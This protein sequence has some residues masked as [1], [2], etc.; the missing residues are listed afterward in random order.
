MTSAIPPPPARYDIYAYVHK[1]L[2]FC[3]TESLGSVGRV[4]ALDD[5]DVARV[6]DG[7]RELLAL[8][9]RHLQHE[10]RHLHTALQA[11]RPGSAARTAGDHLQ[12]A[13]AIGVLHTQVDEVA[14]AAVGDRAA[15]LRGL[16]REL[17]LF[18][19]DNL[20]HMHVEETENNAVLWATHSDDEL[21]A[22]EAAIVASHAPQEIAVVLRWMVP[23]MAPAERATLLAG[24]AQSAPA[25][26]FA[27]V[28]DLV[29]Q[30]ITP[31]DWFK[32]TL[33]LG[34]LPFAAS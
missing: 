21:R 29:K 11:R 9:R 4:D 2:R 23:S 28:L 25:E 14:A 32:L 10:D 13:Q 8:C 22:I 3:L 24:I 31:R 15:V 34:P 7:V 16:Y 18:V 19:A 20:E 6:L 1:G 27:D 17:A 12:H 33:A 5:E 30:H 26:A